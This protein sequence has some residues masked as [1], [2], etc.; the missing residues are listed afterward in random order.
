MLWPYDKPNNQNGKKL[1]NILRQKQGQQQQQWST[2][3]IR[4]PVARN[5][6]EHYSTLPDA[7]ST[8]RFR[9]MAADCVHQDTRKR[10]SE[11][12]RLTESRQAA[13]VAAAAKRGEAPERW[14][15]IQMS[16]MRPRQSGRRR[17]SSSRRG[18][19]LSGRCATSGLRPPMPPWP[20]RPDACCLLP[21]RPLGS[22]RPLLTVRSG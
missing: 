11:S 20:L 16:G 7:A 18:W 4:T 5:R 22:L 6:G 10:E 12:E 2:A 21:G 8:A 14:A 19:P 13:E 3:A 15:T 9:S 1:L 17:S